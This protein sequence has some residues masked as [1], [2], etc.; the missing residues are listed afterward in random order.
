MH[1]SE[2]RAL[3]VTGALAVALSDSLGE[4][5]ASDSSALVT[6]AE[7]GPLTIEFLRRVIGLSHSATV[8]LVDRLGAEGL[9][10]RRDGPDARSVSVALTARGRRRAAHLQRTRAETLAAALSALDERER[11]ELA[12]LAEKIVGGL[13]TGRRQARVI[14]RLCDHDACGVPAGCP[15]D[16]AATALGE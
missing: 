14:C 13:T 12:R 15:V 8:R 5:L 11:R 1:T 4:L 7:R 10:E 16:Q 3:N 2:R 9:V 6:L